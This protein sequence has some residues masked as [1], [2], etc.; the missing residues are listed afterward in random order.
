MKSEY[1]LSLSL[2]LEDTGQ[3]YTLYTMG[4]LDE[5]NV[6]SGNGRGNSQVYVDIMSNRDTWITKNFSEWNGYAQAALI[7]F[8]MLA[9]LNIIK[10]VWRFGDATYKKFKQSKSINS[11]HTSNNENIG[12]LNYKITGM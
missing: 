5:N 8:M 11:V 10:M 12:D 6:T 2:I 9:V 1:Q 7:I 3:K 4:I